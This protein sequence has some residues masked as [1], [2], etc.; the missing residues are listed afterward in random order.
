MK[1]SNLRIGT[2]LGGTFAVL[3]LIVL[4]VS[5]VSLLSLRAADAR[6]E[7]FA[8][9]ISART[10]LAAQLR[11]AVDVRAISARNLVLVTSRDDMETEKALVTRA[12]A[13]VQKH[14]ATLKDLSAN[15]AGVPQ[16]A[17]DL[18]AQ[19]DKVEQAYGPVALAIV[20]Q[21]L[22]GKKAEAIAA[23]NEKCR[24][25][26][27]ALTKATDEYAVFSAQRAQALTAE[28]HQK[29]VVDRGYMLAASAIAILVA[30]AAGVLVTRS[31]TQ[32]I[33]HALELAG[34]VAAGDL[35][36]RITVDSTD[37]M[38]KLLSAL[39]LMN[40]N[41]ANVVDQ[42]RQGSD[43]IATGSSQIAAGNADLSQR[44]EEQASNL[45]Q[46]AASM[47]QLTSTVENNAATAREVTQLASSA[48][49][50]A[51][52]GG[53]VVGQVVHTMEAIT[54]S[55]RKIADII[56]VIDGIA[57]QTN[58]LALNAAVEAARAGEQGRGFAVVA[59]EVRSLAQRSAEAAREIKGLINDSVAK[60]EAGSEQVDQA[61]RTMS[62][63]VSQVRRVSEL[64][65]QISS[66]TGEQTRGI[67]QVGDA[68]N[69]LDQVTQ[70]NAAL[71][72][73]SAAAAERLSMQ[74][75]KL[76]ESVSVFRLGG[77]AA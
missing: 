70:Q 31:I 63:I 50:V 24:P 58:I 77:A 35:T 51:V 72:E 5:G 32:P 22:A 54:A 61:G 1:F 36:S 46:T 19:I 23:M 66:A 25:L 67:S 65:A 4:A 27:A 29:Y 3:A 2:R 55:S 59:G 34:R 41:L 28:S 37:E 21:V 45:Q 74:A 15:A 76:V 42:V 9:G 30:I 12:H 53:E 14:L 52:Q 68:V 7:D 44:T 56:G 43:S 71:V 16:Q 40:D 26:L 49:A 60:V 38:G 47:E 18:I 33:G 57:F 10:A 75:S 69:Q 73:Q 48:S 20:N 17:R 11:T 6:F 13:D 39:K 62:D 64:I 8:A